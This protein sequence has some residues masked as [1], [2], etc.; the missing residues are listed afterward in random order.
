MARETLKDYLISK[1]HA[2]VDHISY[3]VDVTGG[4]PGV[5]GGAPSTPEGL[6]KEPNTEIEIIGYGES[7]S[8]SSGYLHHITKD[9]NFYEFNDAPGVDGALAGHRGESLSP[10]AD[11][12]KGDPYVTQG[13]EQDALLDMNSNS[14]YFDDPT[15]GSPTDPVDEL[16]S[17]ISKI[18]GAAVGTGEGAPR[19]AND[20][21]KGITVPTNPS[22]PND[23]V[24]EAS[25]QALKRNNRFNIDNSY[26]EGTFPANSGVDS[27]DNISIPGYSGPDSDNDG[28][29]D[30][31][32]TAKTSFDNLKNIGSS[33]LLKASGYD[34]SVTPGKDLEIVESTL[35][36]I[37]SG[38]LEEA[39]DTNKKVM[40]RLLAMN[41]T[42]FPS[43]VATGESVRAGTGINKSYDSESSNSKSFGSTYNDAVRFTDYSRAQRFKTAFRLVV[44][45]NAAKL[46]FE[47]I[48]NELS[49]KEFKDIKENIKEIAKKT[50]KIHAG[51]LMLGQSRNSTR[52]IAKNYFLNNILTVTDFNYEECFNEGLYSLFG[53]K[54]G[55]TLTKKDL[56][57]NS[58][59]KG[60]MTKSFDFSDAPGFWHAVS[61]SVMNS[62]DQFQTDIGRIGAPDA[63]DTESEKTAV[64][65]LLNEDNKLL[66]VINVIAIIGEKS[67]HSKNAVKNAKLKNIQ[68]TRDPDSL[69][70]LPGHR[71]GKSR[72]GNQPESADNM[73]PSMGSETTLAWEQSSVPSMYLLPMNIIR[74]A[75]T[76]NN[77]FSGE[78]PMAG[79]LGSR[80]VRNT[81]TGLDVDGTAARIPN[82]VVKI[83][84]DRLDAE[85]VPFY[86]HDL[87]T[88]EI[89]SFHAFLSSLTDNIKPQYTSTNGFGRL[90]PIQ[91][92]QGTTRSLSVGFTVYATNREDFDEMWYK[93]NKLVT[94]LYPQWTKGSLVQST[95]TENLENGNSTFYQPFS[96]V[97]GASPII[98]LRVGDVIK[99]NYSRFALAR[100]FGI[101]D[102]EVK[103]RVDEDIKGSLQGSAGAV[104]EFAVKWIQIIRDA[105]VMILVGIFGSPQGLIKVGLNT[106]APALDDTFKRVAAGAAGDAGAAA[107]AEILVNGFANPLMAAQIIQ[108]LKDPNVSGK[109][110]GAERAKTFKYLNPNF[111]DGY[112]CEDDGKTYFTT[113][114]LIVQVKEVIEDT[115]GK[116]Y[117]KA[118]VKDGTSEEL[119][120]KTLI[121]RHEDILNSP[122]KTFSTSATGILFA[123]GSVDIAGTLDLITQSAFGNGKA[124]DA[125]NGTV[126][127]VTSLV[128]LLV[129]NPESTFM[130]PEVNPFT[131]AFHTTRGRGLAGVMQGVSFDWLDQSTPWETDYNARAPIGCNITF[132]FDVIHDIPPGLDHTGYN[133]APLYNVGEIM[134]SVAGDPYSETISESEINFRKAGN[135]GVYKG[136]QQYRTQ[137]TEK[138]KK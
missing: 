50:D 25:I 67:L 117:Y 28:V 26:L 73:N 46:L 109:D 1:G 129:E 23:F 124:P 91:T 88:N 62:L 37:A 105:A 98:R 125:L 74:A 112:F 16:N 5:A 43:G 58:V 96:Q 39:L 52:F 108:D 70:N 101:G 12:I 95:G 110:K 20:L 29:R 137:G 131:R 128:K 3:K 7:E 83:V 122:A 100:T 68:L 102:T 17:I 116:F 63:G 54:S 35:Q 24:V 135:R 75:Q 59:K 71:V 8:I 80:M 130:R 18:D 42:G 30:R 82:R 61:N 121:V 113:K 134:K 51:K 97:I 53:N 32:I 56:N 127:A 76:L 69:P 104:A 9:K 65:K 138:G 78:N 107:L 72:I 11:F 136:G 31:K 55:D 10:P 2:G 84:E 45:I 36:N 123:I 40:S 44:M 4:E 57:K 86:F 132:Q 114:R 111:I 15:T 92:Y 33:L 87:R 85:Y 14:R 34:V 103:A 99:S 19:G 106:L 49:T 126:N 38:D 66:K 27:K 48:T 119:Q 89:I 118:E 77:S 60:R 115:S 6:G 120:K 133:R 41:A 94:L 79:M 93:I 21:L 81:Y 22:S 90:D 13:T 64:S 47:E